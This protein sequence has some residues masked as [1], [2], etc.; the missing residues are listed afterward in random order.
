MAIVVVV[1]LI[2]LA[3]LCYSHRMARKRKNGSHNRTDLNTSGQ[4]SWRDPPTPPTPHLTQY[5]LAVMG[6][7]TQRLGEDSPGGEREREDKD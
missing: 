7:G 6:G 3:K 1:V 2:L 4:A 5:H